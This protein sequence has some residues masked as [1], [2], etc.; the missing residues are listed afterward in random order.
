MLHRFCTLALAS[1]KCSLPLESQH[2]MTLFFQEKVQD[3]SNIGLVVQNLTRLPTN[4]TCDAG[5]RNCKYYMDLCFSLAVKPDCSL[6]KRQSLTWII[7][8]GGS[9]ILGIGDDVIRYIENPLRFPEVNKW[10]AVGCVNEGFVLIT[11]F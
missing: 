4:E 2:S 9:K 11:H 10:N 7:K 5:N 6:M 8:P 3:Y 1:F